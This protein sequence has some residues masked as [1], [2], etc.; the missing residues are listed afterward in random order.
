MT[1]EKIEALTAK[2]DELAKSLV[3]LATILYNLQVIHKFHLSLLLLG[4]LQKLFTWRL[5]PPRKA[6][7]KG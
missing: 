5:I 6:K 1:S 4:G 3:A 7:L 2:V